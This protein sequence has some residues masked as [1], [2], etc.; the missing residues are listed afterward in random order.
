ELPTPPKT[1]RLPPAAAAGCALAPRL[2]NV[3]P[4]E[5]L[6]PPITVSPLEPELLLT[7]IQSASAP[8]MSDD[9]SVKFSVVLAFCDSIK[10]LLLPEAELLKPKVLPDTVRR[11]RFP[12]VLTT[13]R[14]SSNPP[15]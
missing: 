11:L 1:I 6:G 9:L 14:L 12:D 8:L 15:S 3:F 10:M 4:S 2:S 7:L 5:R 13:F